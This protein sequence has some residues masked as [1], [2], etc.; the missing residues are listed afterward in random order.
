M[1]TPP[2]PATPTAA[3]GTRPRA[4][5]YHYRPGEA[6]LLFTPRF[7]LQA[8]RPGGELYDPAT[9]DLRTRFRLVVIHTDRGTRIGR[10]TF[11]LAP[12]QVAIIGALHIGD[13]TCETVE[14]TREIIAALVEFLFR[15][16]NR[17]KI[18][19]SWPKDSYPVCCDPTLW[20][21]TQEATLRRRARNAAGAFVDTQVFGLTK[22][23]WQAQ[24]ASQVHHEGSAS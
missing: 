3:Q 11:R 9:F 21:F 23:A 22:S 12:E 15:A 16:L 7:A 20:H 10:L 18:Q 14:T 19:I 17:E 1:T 6:L 5:Q 13:S 4:G 8:P 24:A 2:P